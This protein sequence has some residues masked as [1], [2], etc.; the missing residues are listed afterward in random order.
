MS[1]F[2]E[3]ENM[4][5]SKEYFSFIK[6]IYNDYTKYIKQYKS[7]TSDYMKKLEQLQEK[8][9]NINTNVIFS[10]TSII[11]RI[12]KQH[13][14][15]T[16]LFVNG[17][18]T[19]IKLLENAIKEKTNIASNYLNKYDESKN[20]LLKNYKNIDKYKDLYMNSMSNVEDL[21]LKYYNNKNNQDDKNKKEKKDKK[22]KIKNAFDLSIITKDQVSSAVLNTK[23]LEKQYKGSFDL[24]E[25]SEKTFNKVGEESTEKMKNLSFEL[26]IKLKDI[27]LDFIVLLKNSFKMPLSEID[28]VLPKISNFE[29]NSKYE[30]FINESYKLN[31]KVAIAQPQKYKL[32]CCHEPHMVNGKYNLNNHIVVTEDGFGELT[33]IDDTP[34]FLTIKMISKH[35]EL[36]DNANIDIK[37]EGEKVKCK[38][39]T[40][41][42]LSFYQ[43]PISEFNILLSDEEIDQLNELLD[44]HHNRVLFLQSLSTFR[45]K[46]IFDFPTDIFN[47]MNDFFCT[48]INTIVRDKDFHSAK[49]I[50]ILSQTYYYLDNKK[51]KIYLQERIKK[52]TLFKTPKFWKEYLEYSIEKEIVKSVKS[53]SINGT[54][55]KENQKESDD[56][57]ANMVFAQLVPIADNMIEFGISRKE[58]REIIK[59]IIKHYNMSEQSITIIDDVIHKDSERKSILLNE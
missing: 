14:D 10:I 37:L 21:I 46:G 59:P 40:S 30:K 48:I 58:I 54:L 35:F 33:F 27:I 56:M 24:I 25:L 11:P 19:T 26:I 16:E 20:N 5:I 4:N 38:E 43:K 6:D 7:V 31:K 22:E 12:V 51:K 49:N 42:L 45:A 1:E 8:Y 9:S 53:E 15:N 28:T 34:T 41:K 3:F 36:I 18:D 44:K 47:L 50:I 32:K 23:K 2:P 52:E 17:I 55:I 39:L 29:D 57:Y 13:I